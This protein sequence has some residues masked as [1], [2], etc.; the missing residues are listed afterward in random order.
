MTARPWTA[1]DLDALRSLLAWYTV[2]EAAHLLGR[3]RA[4]TDTAMR[5]IGLKS[6][7]RHNQSGGHRAYTKAEI[8]YVLGQHER[9]RTLAQISRFIGRSKSG[10]IGKLLSLGYSVQQGMISANSIAKEYDISSKTVVALAKVRLKYVRSS[11][12]GHGKRYRFTD[13][14]AAELRRI[15]DGLTGRAKA[16]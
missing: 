2:A 7:A 16:A 15:L 13:E 4:A 14:Q 10:L 11:G 5:K 1:E 6:P 8:N 3:T 12:K 9:G